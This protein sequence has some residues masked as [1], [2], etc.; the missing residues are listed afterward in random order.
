PQGPA[1]ADG[2]PGAQGPQGEVGP[3][4]TNFLNAP[5]G[6]DLTGTY[7]DPQIKDNAVN[8][9]K[10]LDGS[11]GTVD[12]ADS[13]VTSL[14]IVNGSVSN[15]DLADNAVTSNKIVNGSINTSKFATLPVVNAYREVQFLGSDNIINIIFD[16][17]EAFDTANLHGPMNLD[18]LTASVS[19]YYQV[20]LQ[21]LWNVSIVGYRKASISKNNVIQVASQTTL[22]I[23]GNYTEQNLTALVYLNVGEYMTAKAFQNSGASLA[24]VTAN[25]MMHWVCP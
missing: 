6:G 17:T 23:T 19:G 18:R 22:P 25:F 14:K 5:A 4:G 13:S 9:A 10:I 20:T 7:P 12:L 2:L 1:G 21:V 24:I 3:P 11:V 15:I 8:S 16:D